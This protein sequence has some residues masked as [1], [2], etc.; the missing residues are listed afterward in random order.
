MTAD[1]GTPQRALPAGFTVAVDPEV[2]LLDQGR[3]MVGG[4]PLRLVRLT[5]AGAAAV[6]RWSAGGP[7]G[8]GTAERR[9]AAQL[10]DAG[11]LQPRPD[12][13]A[14]PTAASVTVVVPVRG[15]HRQLLRLLERL[16]PD[17]GGA[18][19]VVHD[20]P[21]QPDPADQPDRPGPAAGRQPRWPTRSGGGLPVAH[22][23][24]PRRVGP[25][26]ARHAG[27]ARVTSALVAFLDADCL[28]DPGWLHL[29]LPH[30]EDP[31]VAAAAPRVVA[32]PPMHVADVQ[33]T[34]QRLLQD[35]D[36]LRSP[37]DLGDRPGPVRPGSRV[38]YV[39][40]AAL[41]LRRDVYQQGGGFDA[42]LHVGEDVDLVWRI[43]GRGWQVR[44]EPAAHVAHDVRVGL[45]RWLGQRYTYGTSAAPLAR[46]HPAAVAPVQLSGSTLAAWLL[47]AGGQRGAALGVAAASTALLAPKLRPVVPHPWP[48]AL[49]L[50]G[51]GHLAAG[52]RLA[53]ALRRVWWPAAVVAAVGRRRWRWS[54]AAVLAE[55]AVQWVRQAPPLPLPWWLVLRL[56]DDMAYG[57]GVW[58]GCL[59]QRT[60]TPLLPEV[61]RWPPR[62]VSPFALGE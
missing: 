41:V 2:R 32:G 60:I 31:A 7:V 43:A 26:G 35:Y 59:R 61:A 46:R 54:A 38:P 1:G 4:A 18:V 47:A 62:R 29:L 5:D 3:V 23:V 50:A 33:P 55:P 51:R 57:A 12:P 22:M 19:V 53:E 15:Q 8:A 21:D 56:A 36:A 14:G 58:A 13:A 30:F 16:G 34:L 44:Y 10:L 6:R 48:E 52:L 49:R 45:R 9:L 27:M 11:L 25:G 28:P 42:S 39:P 17:D 20:G 40:T 37:L 24:L